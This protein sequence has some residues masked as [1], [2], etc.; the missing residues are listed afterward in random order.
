MESKRLFQAL[1]NETLIKV[2]FHVGES[3]PGELNRSVKAQL[4]QGLTVP[5]VTKEDAILAKLVWIK[6]GSHKNRQDVVGMILDPGEINLEI[7]ENLSNEL[8]V[9]AIWQDLLLESKG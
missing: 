7:I 4:F 6:K 5:M 3:I 1:D 9:N 8:G 2:D